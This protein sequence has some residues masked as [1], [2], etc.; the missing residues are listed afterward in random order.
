MLIAEVS[1]VLIHDTT[2][3]EIWFFFL[4]NIIILFFVIISVEY[5]IKTVVGKS[6]LILLFLSKS[7]LFY[8]RQDTSNWHSRWYF[9]ISRYFSLWSTHHILYHYLFPFDA[10]IIIIF[11]NF[12][13]QS[14]FHLW[15]ISLSFNFVMK[16]FLNTIYFNNVPCKKFAK[17]DVE[18]VYQ[19]TMVLINHI[20]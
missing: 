6:Y 7:I 18:I 15:M 19:H 14:I 10:L 17:Y 1:I 9:I 13:F 5:I 20:I 3:M 8:H 12:F 11:S 2:Y 16:Y 4:Q